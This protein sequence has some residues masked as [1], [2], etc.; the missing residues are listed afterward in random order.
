[1]IDNLNIMSNP[2]IQ[3]ILQ[4]EI[5]QTWKH[6]ALGVGVFVL[7]IFLKNIFT[8]YIV[9]FLNKIFKK[10]NFKWGI[11]VVN[12][13]ETPFK[14][15][16]ILIGGYILART[17]IPIIPIVTIKVVDRIMYSCIVIILCNGLMNISKSSYDIFERANKK[18]DINIGNMVA[19]LVIKS[20]NFIIISFGIIQIAYI[21]NFNIDAFITGLGL[22]GLAISLAAKDFAA[23][24]IS[25][26]IIIF[27]KPFTLGDWIR[28]KDLEGVVE[29]V[30]FR[31][32]K[33]RTPDKVLISVPNSI[34]AN[35]SVLNFNKRDRRRININIGVSYSTSVYKIKTCIERIKAILLENEN[36]EKDMIQV[37][38]D[39]FNESSLD[40]VIYCYSNK[41]NFNE[42]MDTKEYINYKIMEI[43]EQEDVE[44]AFPTRSIYIETNQEK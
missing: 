23:N 13:F 3:M 26:A 15:L 43:F 14:M 44:I 8:K 35:E 42:Y 30:S 4:S 36:I 21:W 7:I 17:M 19:P 11:K 40:I 38:F 29:D 10:L 22:G 20:I 39:K 34:L 9:R 16:F 5:Y 2:Y 33:I 1:M 18:L 37:S 28:C 24:M 12:A 6:V 27:D 32:T 41:I 31:S 25:G